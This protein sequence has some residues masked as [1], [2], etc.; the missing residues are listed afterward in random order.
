MSDTREEAELMEEAYKDT[1]AYHSFGSSYSPAIKYIMNFATEYK[2]RY[3]KPKNQANKELINAIKERI[4]DNSNVEITLLNTMPVDNLIILVGD[5]FPII[6]AFLSYL[7]NAT[8]Q[9]WH[10]VPPCI[11]VFNTVYNNV[12][13]YS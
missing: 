2:K 4:P 10:N 5:E 8:E 11:E 12:F 3:G 13:L 1:L 9:I 7:S 6:S